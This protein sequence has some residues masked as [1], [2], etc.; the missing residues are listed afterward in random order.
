MRK[1][2]YVV[3]NN[4]SS[5]DYITDYGMFGLSMGIAELK[6]LENLNFAIHQL[7][8]TD[9]GISDL[10]E[11]IKK[12]SSLKNLKLDVERWTWKFTWLLTCLKA[13]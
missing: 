3:L 5:P 4:V 10:G 1:W 7:N 9:K 6:S 8:I 2:R 11:G 13:P 12:L